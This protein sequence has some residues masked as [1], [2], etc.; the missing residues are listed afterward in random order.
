MKKI[1]FLLILMLPMLLGACSMKVDNSTL[2]MTISRIR[3]EQA[4]IEIFP[5]SNDFYYTYGAVKVEEYNSYR[6]DRKFIEADYEENERVCKV[7]NELFEEY[8]YPTKSI[9]E[10]LYFNGAIDEMLSNLEPNTDYYAFA[11]CLNSRKKPIHTLIKQP[12]TTPAKPH[13]DI[14]FDVVMTDRETARITPTNHDTYYWEASTKEAVFN[15]YEI[16][17]ND[18]TYTASFMIPLWFGSV[19]YTNYKW[20]FDIVSTGVEY[21]H[22]SDFTEHL[23]DGDIFYL[24]CVGYTTEETTKEYLYQITY[25][26]ASPSTIEQVEN[27]LDDDLDAALN[28]DNNGN[29]N[30]DHSGTDNTTKQAPLRLI[31]KNPKRLPYLLHHASR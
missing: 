18:T 23:R 13:S 1:H 14:A 28:T 20:D 22:L 16:D 6:N 31:N 25:H 9:E 11:Y 3:S 5:Q 27:S 29:L 26:T 15:Y 21:V 12:F 8:G 4:G 2:N 7:L 19:I 17:P 30:T 24:A 10:L